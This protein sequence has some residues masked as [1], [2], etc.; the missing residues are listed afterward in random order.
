MHSAA[1]LFRFY[2]VEV[3]NMVRHFPILAGVLAFGLGVSLLAA[4]KPE[5]KE[6]CVDV[7]KM[8]A[9]IERLEKAVTVDFVETGAADA[10]HLFGELTGLALDTSSR[11]ADGSV[12]L[13][14]EQQP[15]A[16]VLQKILDPSRSTYAVKPSGEI[17]ILQA[18]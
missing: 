6:V 16:V 17:L 5:G 10:L 11:Q 4:T 12:S 7:A 14:V 13:H 9:T 1:L 18:K 3:F 8:K 2:M 15:A